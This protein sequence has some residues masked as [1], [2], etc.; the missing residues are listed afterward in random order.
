VFLDDRSH[1]GVDESCGCREL[2]LCGAKLL[3]RDIGSTVALDVADRAGANAS[4]MAELDLSQT[5]GVALAAQL[6]V[7]IHEISRVFVGATLLQWVL[8]LY[9]ISIKTI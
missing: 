6:M 4:P 7:T 3:A 2:R 9:Y 8:Q 5:L 1:E